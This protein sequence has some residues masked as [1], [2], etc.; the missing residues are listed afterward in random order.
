ME[1]IGYV[2]ILLWVKE[3]NINWNPTLNNLPMQFLPTP[4]HSSFSESAASYAFSILYSAFAWFVFVVHYL[5]FHLLTKAKAEMFPNCCND[6][7]AYE[8]FIIS[9]R[10]LNCPFREVTSEY[11]WWQV[12]VTFSHLQ[13]VSMTAWDAYE[14]GVTVKQNIGNIHSTYP[15]DYY[16]NS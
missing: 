11:P 4:W 8:R 3:F 14:D 9:E 10:L 7:I 5:L 16:T 2:S 13:R 1:N 12:L 6:R 15:S